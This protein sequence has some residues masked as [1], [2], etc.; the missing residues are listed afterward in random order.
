MNRP[1]AQDE[2]TVVTKA[3]WGSMS[4]SMNIAYEQAREEYRRLMIEYGEALAADAPT[5]GA[6]LANAMAAW[7]R[8]CAIAPAGPEAEVGMSMH[9]TLAFSYA[10][11]ANSAAEAECLYN[12]MTDEDR[13][14]IDKCD[15]R[16]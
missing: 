13:R 14:T 15:A 5:A 9:L 4:N 11:G 10:S 16:E 2:H 8:I 6:L 1:N 7:I 12:Q 3:V